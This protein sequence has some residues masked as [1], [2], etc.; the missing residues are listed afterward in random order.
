MAF[1]GKVDHRSGLVGLQELGDPVDIANVALHKDMVR[2]VLQG[3]QGFQIAS[4][5]QLVQIDHGFRRLGQ[6]IQNEIGAYEA[7]T[8]SDKKS[9]KA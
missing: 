2:V 6:P 4:V 5:S 8:T 9:H 1:G 7:G 3:G